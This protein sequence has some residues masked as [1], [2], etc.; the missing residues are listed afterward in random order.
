VA[1][2][3]SQAIAVKP[4]EP[5]IHVMLVDHW[6]RHGN[7][8]QAVTAAQSALV[9]LPESAIL[10][11]ALG[12]AQLANNEVAQSLA[13]FGK[14]SQQHPKSALAQIRVADAHLRANNPDAAEKSLRKALDAAPNLLVVQRSL[15]LLAIQARQPEKA[16]QIAR[17][18]Q[19]Q[20]PKD[21]IGHLM[22]G[23]IHVAFKSTD[24]A[25]KALRAG[26]NKQG[27][28]VVAARLH[29]TLT[30]AGRKADGERFADEWI[31]QHPK[32]TAL[33][34]HLAEDAMKAGDWKL[35]EALYRQVIQLEPRN[36]AAANNLAWT[37]A[38][39]GKPGAV[40]MAQRALAL[41]PANAG[42]LDTLAFALGEEGQ[43]S[44]AIET[45]KSAVHLAPQAASF[46]FTLARLYLKDNDK[47][48]AK[49]ELEELAKLGAKF[50]RHQEVTDLMRSL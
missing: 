10:L 7:P 6:L 1:Q 18:I 29:R 38:K 14:L 45:S 11:D 49:A 48:S 50:P 25:V 5:K 16:L 34:V 12:R 42:T 19:E 40:D 21:A 13:T 44:K 32:D 41:A 22:E 2:L 26:L 8:G 39:A 30:A 36:V 24:A 35:A 37:L 4:D 31:R 27:G 17:T 33:R 47:K 23:D 9:A 46:R 43:L 3:L 20:R 28:G 15:I